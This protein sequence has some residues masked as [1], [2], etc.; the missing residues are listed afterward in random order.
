[1]LWLLLLPGAALALAAIWLLLIRPCHDRGRTAVFRGF[2]YAHR[3]LH[4]GDG[5]V[6]ENSL[7]AFR[8]AVDAG[9]GIELDVHLTADAKLVVFHDF[10]LSRMCGIDLRVENLT[11]DALRRY[12]LLGSGEKIPLFDEVLELV[13]GKVPLVI[14][15]KATA[16]AFGLCELVNARLQRYRGEYCIESFNPL[17]LH[18]YRRRAPEVYRGLLSMD[19]RKSDQRMN[20]V[21]K[22]ALSNL[23]LN[24]FAGPQFL[25]YRFSDR[26]NR[27]LQTCRRLYHAATAAW[28]IRTPQEFAKAA[29][30]FDFVIFEGFEPGPVP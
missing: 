6:P 22:G 29:Q 12:E 27:S 14:E 16:N 11:A 3:G 9:Y 30:E 25:S 19:Y 1:M 23:L 17:V 8:R 5:R 2:H 18:W 24:W 10:L 15:L 13:G 28:T 4:T 7:A 26:S 20:R 21:F